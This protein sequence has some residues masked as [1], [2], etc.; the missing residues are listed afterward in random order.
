M[1]PTVGLPPPPPEEAEPDYAAMLAEAKRYNDAILQARTK[2]EMLNRQI[3]D[4]ED[5]RLK[6][7]HELRGL[8]PVSDGAL[9]QAEDGL[10]EG[11][12]SLAEARGEGLPVSARLG[13]LPC[14][15]VVTPS[16]LRRL[17]SALSRAYAGEFHRIRAV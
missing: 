11:E 12:E 10:K 5:D 2:L 6:L 7:V 14:G 15:I 4:L 16:C 8:C 17:G 9:A 3:H 13:V 1:S